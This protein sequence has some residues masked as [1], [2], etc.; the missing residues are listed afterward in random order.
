MQGVASMDKTK[1]A[2]T[3]FPFKF[4][5]FK[6]EKIIRRNRQAAQSVPD[7]PGIEHLLLRSL[8]HKLEIPANEHMWRELALILARDKYPEPLPEGAPKKWNKNLDIALIGEVTRLRNQKNIVAETTSHACQLL[9]KNELWKKITTSKSPADRKELLRK[10]YQELKRKSDFFNEAI[11]QFKTLST[12]K[13]W[14]LFIESLE[15]EVDRKI[16]Q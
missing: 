6:R 5:P 8:A 13:K 1:K 4:P 2:L 9:A 10:R 11:L 7:Q 16:S 14:P 15:Q 12:Q 3:E